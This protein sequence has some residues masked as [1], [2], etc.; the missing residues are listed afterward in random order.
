D[1]GAAGLEPE[2][3][4]VLG[5]ADGERED[6]DAADLDGPVRLQHHE[7]RRRRELV[8]VHGEVGRLHLA[9]DE[10]AWVA[11]DGGGVEGDAVARAVEGGEE[12][13]A[14]DVVPVEVGEEDVEV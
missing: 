13:E 8:E 3:E 1:A 4:D 5:V 10:G 7:A 9:L 2:A 6:L 11:V 14:L 12:G